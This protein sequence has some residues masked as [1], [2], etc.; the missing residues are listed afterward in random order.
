ML[1]VGRTDRFAAPSH[2]MG[3]RSPS[4]VAIVYY[5]AIYLFIYNFSYVVIM[6]VHDSAL[7]TDCL[8]VFNVFFLSVVFLFLLFML[9]AILDHVDGPQHSKFA[10]L[11]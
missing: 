9:A 8:V 7:I 4:V 11:C 3:D 6:S 5:H 1:Y 10:R 2:N